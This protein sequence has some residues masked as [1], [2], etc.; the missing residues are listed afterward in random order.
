MRCFIKANLAPDQLG[1]IEILPCGVC[2]NR[3]SATPEFAD[4]RSEVEL[5]LNGYPRCEL[6]SDVPVAK[7]AA[8]STGVGNDADG[9][10]FFDPLF[11]GQREAVQARLH[12]NPV[13]FHGIKIRVVETFP[14]AQIGT[15]RLKPRRRSP[16]GGSK[17]LGIATDYLANEFLADVAARSAAL[18]NASPAVRI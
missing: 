10:S 13:E 7:R 9:P 16:G 3:E 12:F 5:E 11:G 6:E 14:D 4:R 2:S 18:R 17:R 1:D 8:V 15:Q